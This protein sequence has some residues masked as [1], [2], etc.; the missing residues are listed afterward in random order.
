M[1]CV[2]SGIIKIEAVALRLMK[3]VLFAS[4]GAMTATVLLGVCFRYILKAP[5]PWGEELARYLMIWSASLGASVAFREGSHVGVTLIMDQFHG[6]TGIALTKASQFIVILFMT[7]VMIEG[8]VLV[9]KL[10]GQTSTA[11]EIPMAWAYLAIPVGCLLI[12]LEALIMI[13]FKGHRSPEKSG[14]QL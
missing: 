14:E 11:M 1:D 2:Q 4:T 8:F 7:V 13:F 3:W 10:R 5:L 6:K 9:L 12:L